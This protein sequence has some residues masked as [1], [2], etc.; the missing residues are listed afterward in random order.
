M[1]KKELLFRAFEGSGLAHVFYTAGGTRRPRKGNKKTHT[2]NATNSVCSGST[3]IPRKTLENWPKREKL[4]ESNDW[5]REIPTET[6]QS[7][8]EKSTNM[9]L[10]MAHP[11][12]VVHDVRI[13]NIE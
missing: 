11:W 3:K 1:A 10:I 12:A 13:L 6:P 4:F 9:P 2:D 5:Q 7:L 8:Q